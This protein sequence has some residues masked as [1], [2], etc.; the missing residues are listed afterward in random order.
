MLILF[1][2]NYQLRIPV[3]VGF[4]KITFTIITYHVFVRPLIVGGYVI[5]FLQKI[6]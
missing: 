4:A 3:F 5:Y 6:S 2:L 1:L